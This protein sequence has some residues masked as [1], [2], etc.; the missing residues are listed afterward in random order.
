VGERADVTGWCYELAGV[1]G[2]DP[3]PFTLAELLR[4][5][6]G[7]WDA[8]TGAIAAVLAAAF[9]PRGAPAAANPYRPRAETKPPD[10]SVMADVKAK[11]FEQ[12]LRDIARKVARNKGG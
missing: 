6:A 4:M 8:E 12:G 10:P 1:A 5:A 7:R 9:R 3:G 2:I 11:L